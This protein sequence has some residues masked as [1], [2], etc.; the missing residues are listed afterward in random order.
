MNNQVKI[1]DLG[2]MD[3][4]PSWEFQKN[5][6]KDVLVGKSRHSYPC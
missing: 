3:Y 5:F 2:K 4:K 1:L 6:H